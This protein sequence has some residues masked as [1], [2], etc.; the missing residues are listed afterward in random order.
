MQERIATQ[1]PD[2]QVIRSRILKSLTE[3]KNKVATTSPQYKTAAKV[4]ARF[5]AL[6]TSATTPAVETNKSGTAA[7]LVDE[8]AASLPRGSISQDEYHA[9]LKQITERCGYRLSITPLDSGRNVFH[10]HQKGSPEALV[11]TQDINEI[12]D[13]LR[14]LNLMGE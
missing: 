12:I 6:I 13:W 4:L 14:R 7:P 11:S 1:L 5:I 10:V 2:L 3:G 9:S 8:I